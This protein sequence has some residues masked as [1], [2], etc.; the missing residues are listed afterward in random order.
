MISPNFVGLY[1]PAGTDKAIIE[2]LSNASAKVMAD[3][4]VKRVL[5]SAGMET[6]ADSNPAVAR[7]YLAGEIARW[8][9]VI[10]S[11]GLRLDSGG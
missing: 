5:V 3:A 9:P 7:R 4:D 10:K 11:I 8:T 6:I 2:K 1:A